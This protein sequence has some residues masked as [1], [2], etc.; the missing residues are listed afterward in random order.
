MW[1]IRRNIT[2]LRRI[3]CKVIRLA[4][5]VQEAAGVHTKISVFNPLF[6][7]HNHLKVLSK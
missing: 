6:D 4:G 5:G 3:K 1:A 7:F 2:R